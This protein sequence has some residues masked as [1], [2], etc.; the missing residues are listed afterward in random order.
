MN[1]YRRCIDCRCIDFD[2]D[3]LYFLGP[4]GVVR[5]AFELVDQRNTRRH[6]SQIF[7][8]SEL[9]FQ[10]LFPFSWLK[11]NLDI[12]FRQT[13]LFSRSWCHSTGKASLNT[14]ITDMTRRRALILATLNS[15][16]VVYFCV[17][18]EATDIDIN[19]FLHKM[20]MAFFQKLC[21]W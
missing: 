17:R 21:S 14:S 3:S 8:S 6:I 20:C 16:A 10:G 2:Y 7:Y 19:V 18:Q 5:N 4:C 12:L 1:A 9:E 13:L 11:P 15:W